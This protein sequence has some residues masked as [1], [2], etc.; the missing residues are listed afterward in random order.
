M[1]ESQSSQRGA[2]EGGP[3][4]DTDSL[5][6]II[7][8]ARENALS[9]FRVIGTVAGAISLF[10]LLPGVVGATSPVSLGMVGV[11]TLAITFGLVSWV[12][13]ARRSSITA[14]FLLV[15]TSL[16]AVIGTWTIGPT[17]SMGTL[18]VVVPVLASLFYGRRLILPSLL[19]TAALLVA[20]GL[21]SW[22]GG[23]PVVG[24]VEGASAPY[25]VYV[26]IAISSFGSVAMALAFVNAVLRAMEASIAKA[27]AAA[28]K[29]AEEQERRLAA[30]RE[31]ARAKRLEEIGRL[32]SGVAHDTRNALLVLS[33]G[34]RELRTGVEGAEREAVLSDLE[35]AVG[36]VSSTVQQLLSLARRE[37][38]AARPVDLAAR[39]SQFASALRRVL[40]P[41]VEVRVECQGTA[42]AVLDPSRLEQALLNLALNARDAMPGGG[43]L[44]LRLR[45][46]TRLAVLEVEDSGIG[47]EPGTAA[48]MFE[49]FFTTKG[50]GTG[51]G[52]HMVRSFVE[53]VGGAIEVDSAV[54]QGTRVRLCFPAASPQLSQAA[55]A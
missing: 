1:A 46:R 32:A 5:D 54:G 7:V 27:R 21:A 47:M 20:V 35:H 37:S 2:P 19:A 30:E 34:V 28:R 43:R 8:A 12:V 3:G 31:L 9:A 53:G 6:P 39:L 11:L 14:G 40:P 33:A 44:V 23:L 17:F 42:H 52:L 10:A 36:G 51:L 24:H 50:E 38:S 4:P 13:P 49:P 29:A 18:F 26:R 25:P 48:R 16:I 55:G 15:G 45:E 41:E 22:F